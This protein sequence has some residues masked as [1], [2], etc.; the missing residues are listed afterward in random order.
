[1]T[2]GGGEMPLAA[3]REGQV[4]ASDV[5]APGD[6]DLD[7]EPTGVDTLPERR[8]REAIPEPTPAVRRRLIEALLGL[9]FDEASAETVA[10]AVEDPRALI[11][12][13][14][15]PAELGVHGG[16]IRYVLTRVRNAAV[17]PIPTNPRVSGEVHYAAGGGS[18]AGAIEALTVEGMSD[19]RA[20]LVITSE[21]QSR[22][23]QD[24]QAAASFVRASNPLKESVALQG[25]LLPV[26]LVPVQ[27]SFQDGSP[28]RTI[29]CTIDGSSRLTAAMDIWD[30][31]PEEVLFDLSDGPRLRARI[32][33][34]QDL[35]SRDVMDLT[36]DDRAR[37]RTRVLP[38]QLIVGWEAEEDGLAFPD[39]LDA[40]LGLLHVEP[41][42]PWGEAAG[43]DSRAEAVLDELVRLG[44][45]G[46]G[47]AR[48]L[49]GHMAPD[50]ALAAGYDPSLDGR[51]AAV[52]HALDR[53]RNAN[54]VNRALR[55]IGMRRPAR[56]DRLEVATE[57][58]MRPY[59]RQV[60]DLNRRNPRQALPAAMESLRP[61]ETGWSPATSDPQVLLDAALAELGT[62][63]GRASRA[64]LAVRGA[65]WLTRYSSLQ[66]SSRVDPRLADE[67]LREIHSSEHGLRCLYQA[68]VDGRAG[69]VPR[70]VRADGSIVSTATGV[71]PAQTDR[72]LRET[73]P[74]V[75]VS[76]DSAD[77]G[78]SDA[79]GENVVAPID[80]LRD[81]IYGLR[82][83]A[84]TVARRVA[85]LLEVVEDGHPLVERV[86]IPSDVVADIS[87]DLDKARTRVSI[88]GDIW[89]RTSDVSAE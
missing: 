39:I 82:D 85:G 44:R 76:D 16:T 32:A 58:A 83:E 22:V 45:V 86:G 80:I 66:K 72:W 89:Q 21:S 78:D 61:D 23:R 34:V 77:G 64:E 42:T 4:E 38:A 75:D 54:A 50:D 65:F 74:K 43:Q 26:T 62:G 79:G 35:L 9:G 48:Y 2:V 1:M 15:A 59:R 46:E 3:A 31:S 56:S 63:V 7:E 71:E 49:A 51:A 69:V 11:E 81:R 28:A 18:S 70:Q 40:Y 20:G 68:I 14:K 52:F 12:Q 8:L 17:L 5:A 13:L 84:S 24:M 27:F 87:S 67:V 60:A 47:F 53:R 6:G 19:D 73:F 41:P 55:R 57:L 25:I 33:A 10:R 36:G 37:L 30:L 88:L 29:L